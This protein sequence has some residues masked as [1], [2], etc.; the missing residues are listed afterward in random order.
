MATTLFFQGRVTA[1][2]GS[3][4][5]TDPSALETAG[6]SAKGIVALLGTAEGGIP[7]TAGMEAADFMIATRPEHVR[8]LFAAGDLREAGAM[9]YDASSD[10]DIQGSPQKVIFMKTNQSTPSSITLSNALGQVGI[11][12]SE[13]YGAATGQIAISQ[14]TASPGK[15]LSVVKAD[16]TETATNIGGNNVL[17]LEYIPSPGLGWETMVAQVVSS[18]IRAIGTRTDVG[19]VDQL[20]AIT[21]ATAGTK[22]TVTATTADANKTATIYGLDTSNIP[23][24]ETL[25][26]INGTVIGNKTWNRVDGCAMSATPAGAVTIKEATGAVLLITQTGQ[27]YRGVIPT[28]TM[29]VAGQPLSLVLDS[30]SSTPEVVIWG[31]NAAGVTISERVVLTGSVWKATT[32]SWS[33]IDWIV[34]GQLPAARTLTTGAVAAATSNAVQVTIK[35]AADYMNARQIAGPYGFIMTLEVSNQGFLVA[36]LDLTAALVSDASP[37]GVSIYGAAAEFKADLWAVLSFFNTVSQLTSMVKTAFQAELTDVTITPSAATFT[38]SAGT[39]S[40]IYT[41]GPGTAADVQAGLV[42]AW[43]NNPLLAARG[44]ASAKS[45]NIVEIASAMPTPLAI[46]VGAGLATAVIQTISGV[47]SV[48]SNFT[49]TYLTGGSEGVATFTDYQNALN[50]LKK[51]RVNSVVVLSPDPAVAAA[52]DAHCAFMCGIGRSERDG[53]VGIM[54]AGLTGVP[55]KTETKTQITAIN[56]RHIRAYAQAVDRYDTIGNKVRFMPPFQAVLAAGMQ[57]SAAVGTSLTHKYAKVLSIAQDVSWNPID[58]SDEMINAG[59]S[60]MEA[61]DGKGIRV[62]RN[63]TTWLKDNN[64]AFIEGSVNEAVNFAVYEFRGAMEVAVGK[65]GFSGTISAAKGVA[66]NKLSSLLDENAIVAWQALSL[67]SI[68]DVLEVSVQIAPVIPINFVLSTVHLV[69]IRQAA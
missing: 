10:S 60:F 4:S 20:A 38:I 1:T 32:S 31:R 24:R 48:P 11:V 56:S 33:A 22:V 58:D 46:S 15:T 27:Q 35:Q 19:E 53:F 42:A 7:V 43:N 18:G 30:G 47:G 21:L 16:Q 37:T 64:L 51:I 40:A 41:S 12:T 9:L 17:N 34:L 69:T 66:G 45:T 39:Q 23:Q 68:L 67:E 52:L 62:V 59:L 55:T 29:F 2:P 65:P 8:K 36:D 26:L 44:L 28:A 63:V 54:N 61:V 3:Y 50:L 6:L 14:A 25:T 57:A 5:I 49:T 13:D